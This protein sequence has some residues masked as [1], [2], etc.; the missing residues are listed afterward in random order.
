LGPVVGLE[1]RVDLPRTSPLAP[2]TAIGEVLVGAELC[3]AF[4]PLMPCATL[5]GLRRTYAQFGEIAGVSWL[6]RA[7]AGVYLAPAEARVGSTVGVRLDADLGPTRIYVPPAP[8]V[9]LPWWSGRV[10]ARVVVRT[11]AREHSSN[12]TEPDPGSRTRPEQR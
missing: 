2:D 6:P 10:E 3:R 5:G 12:D 1:L 9:A 7:G 11:G 4:G 8:P